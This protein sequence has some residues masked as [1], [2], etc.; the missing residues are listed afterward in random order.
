MKTLKNIRHETAIQAYLING[1]NQ[2]AAYRE[3]YPKS[4][5]WKENVVAKRASEL[6]NRGEVL[7]R[8]SEIQSKMDKENIYEL[9][10]ILDSFGKI[11]FANICDIFDFDEITGKIML[12]GNAKRLS[13]L[14]RDITD[15]IQS[16]KTTKDGIE[17]KLY[18]KDKALEQIA[19]MKGYYAP[20]KMI[21]QE[22][23]LEDLLRSE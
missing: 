20:D 5:K 10:R 6:F 4:V 1:G 3:A 9:N 19:K 12:I 7:G 23:T 17:V 11:A 21:I 16:L 8:L 2:S 15:C 13:G 22:T 14:S 18:S